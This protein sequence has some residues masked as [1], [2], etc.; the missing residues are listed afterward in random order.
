MVGPKTR[1]VVATVEDV[2]AAV[3]VEVEIEVGGESVD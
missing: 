2:Q 3:W 1:R